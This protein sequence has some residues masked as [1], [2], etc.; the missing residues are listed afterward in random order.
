MGNTNKGANLATIDETCLGGV[1]GGCRCNPWGVNVNAQMPPGMA[2]YSTGYYQG[3]NANQQFLMMMIM[4][5][6][7]KK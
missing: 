4:M 5:M 6:S 1:T 2:A 3:W 7:K